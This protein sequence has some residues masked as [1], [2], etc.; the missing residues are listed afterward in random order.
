MPVPAEATVDVSVA[1]ARAGGSGAV[2]V[3]CLT[4]F[5]TGGTVGH[6]LVEPSAPGI[7]LGGGTRDGRPFVGFPT[8][9]PGAIDGTCGDWLSTGTPPHALFEMCHDD[10]SVVRRAEVQTRCWFGVFLGSIGDA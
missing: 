7:G 2:G 8:G 9:D 5:G 10:R 4:G 1:T 3:S 6:S